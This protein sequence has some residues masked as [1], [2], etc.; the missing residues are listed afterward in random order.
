LPAAIVSALPS[1]KGPMTM[2]RHKRNLFIQGV[3]QRPLTE[4]MGWA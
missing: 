4:Q 2:A 1:A 3:S